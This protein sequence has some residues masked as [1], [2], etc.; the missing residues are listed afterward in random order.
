ME[1]CGKFPKDLLC[2]NYIQSASPNKPV[3]DNYSL[4]LPILQS[5]SVVILIL[6]YF[7]SVAR[8]R[9]INAQNLLKRL[10]SQSKTSV[11]KLV[12]VENMGFNA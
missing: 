12:P 4:Q 5:K 10:V 3:N 6:P 9:P 7:L 1:F 2:H 11:P 8:T